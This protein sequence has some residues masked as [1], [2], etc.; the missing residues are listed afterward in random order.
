MKSKQLFKQKAL[1]LAVLMA[2]SPFVL[3]EEAKPAATKTQETETQSEQANAQAAKVEALDEVTVKSSK[4][5]QKDGYQATKTRVG[6]TLQDP[7]DVPQA[8]TTITRSLM[9]D[10]QVGSLREA[11]RNVSGL[12]FNA[13]EGGRSGDNINLRG[14]YTFGDIYLDGIRDTAQYNRE[15]FNLEQIDVLRGS[16]AMLFGRG[17]AGGVINQVSKTPQLNDKNTIT[18]SMGEESYQQFTGDFNKQLTDS[19]AVRLNVM[20]REEE[21]WRKNPTTG[22]H[23]E[24]DRKGIAGSIGFGIK[25][26][27]ELLLSHIYTK[28]RDVPDYGVSFNNASAANGATIAQQNI[29]IPVSSL[30]RRPTDNF[31][32]SAFYGTNDNFDDSETKITTAT[33]THKFTQDMQ[34]RS[35]VRLADYERQYWAK[36]PA[37]NLAPSANGSVGGNQ[38]RTSD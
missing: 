8:V 24:L 2:I 26:D 22:D 34:L 6:K 16:A 12:T 37:N 29:Q 14:F 20:Q 18:G 5:A 35:Q 31:S 32:S 15:T 7:H 13:A 11:L 33:F 10:Q 3:A 30:T 19:I 1:T 4:E 23:P 9:H 21:T 17:Q 25:T 38:T 28:T 27:D 36:T